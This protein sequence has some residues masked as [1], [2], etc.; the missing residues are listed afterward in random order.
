[1]LRDKIERKPGDP[2]TAPV[3]DSHA[4]VYNPDGDAVRD[5]MR[6][7]KPGDPSSS[8]LRTVKYAYTPVGQLSSVTK[9]GVQAGEDE[10]YGYDVAGNIVSSTVGKTTT[11][12]SFVHNRLASTTTT[13]DGVPGSVSSSYGY[14]EIGRLMTVTGAGGGE[15]S[16]YTYDGFDRVVAET[17]GSNSGSGPAAVST[18]SRFDP[19]DRVTVKAVTKGSTTTRTRFNYVGVSEQVAAEERSDATHSWQVTKT[20]AYGPDGKPL[21]LTSTP[22]TGGSKTRFYTTSVHGDV[23]ALT[24]P[25]TGDVTS[26][27]RY[28]AYGSPDVSGTLGEDSTDTATGGSA[29]AD[30]PTADVLNP[31]R[32]SSKR[33]DVASGGY[34]MG[35]RN[36][37]PGL[38][39]FLSRDMYNGALADV[40]LG[41]DPWNAN[42]YAF[43]GGNPISHIE[44]DGHLARELDRGGIACDAAC[45][46]GVLEAMAPAP[47]EDDGGLWG[48][49]TG[50]AHDAAS[51]GMSAIKGYQP[52]VY[53]SPSG[54]R[55]RLAGAVNFAAESVQ[56]ANDTTITGLFLGNKHLGSKASS[57]FSNAV[58]ADTNSDSFHAGQLGA[59]VASLVGGPESL[60]SRGGTAAKTAEEAADAALAGGRTSG[61]AAE[62]NAGGHT[63]VDVSTGGAERVLHPD[64]QAALDAVPAALRAPWHGA[65]A[66]MGC[67]S[68]ALGAGV[69]P[70]GGT[71]R[72]VAIG[73]SNPGHGLPKLICS[74]CMAVM[75]RFGISVG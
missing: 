70:L 44:L 53:Y 6:V 17:H 5:I 62:L 65:C 31:Y 40:S 28:T 48:T 3:V 71:M 14:D 23:E 43:A 27:Y 18:S 67:I 26:S 54:M 58:G 16:S 13:T 61:A 8:L 41:M 64:V 7:Q 4:L 69:D 32:Y 47:G 72:A 35:F 59:A 39:S 11:A 50:A 21:V 12:S 30:D 34:D 29:D 36:Y 15:E 25:V 55:D 49:V 51:W 24:D 37:D 52:E 57:A 63:F 10:S 56:A 22:L 19:F 42:R 74:S 46:E 45:Q 9:Q 38:N 66:E 75:E 68:Q 2:A 33:I 1:L 20:Y 60:A 73:S